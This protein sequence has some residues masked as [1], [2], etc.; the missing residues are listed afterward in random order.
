MVEKSLEESFWQG[1]SRTEDFVLAAQKMEEEGRR[2][3]SRIA[4][5]S[6]YYSRFMGT[7]LKNPVKGFKE[8][9]LSQ[10]LATEALKLIQ[11][12][13][14][15]TYELG[16]DEADVLSTLLSRRW[17]WL[18]GDI[19]TAWEVA[20]RAL[21]APDSASH[22]RALLYVTCAEILIKKFGFRS[23]AAEYLKHAI[24]IAKHLEYSASVLEMR[25]ITRVY[26]RA[27]IMYLRLG[28]KSAAKFYIKRAFEIATSPEFGAKDQV[29]KIK[30]SWLIARLPRLLRWFF[31]D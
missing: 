21:H 20:M 9:A 6:Q 25:Q 8:F 16:P 28:C 18:Q 19:S 27:A 10:S 7:T 3:E 17:L 23:V 11:A 30:I 4:L 2:I 5:A 15:K 14:P 13:G 1:K 12:E 26:R 31:P 22:T 29:K 24:D